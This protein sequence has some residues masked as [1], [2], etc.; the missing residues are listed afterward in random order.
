MEADEGQNLHQLLKRWPEKE[1]WEGAIRDR[2][3]MERRP[4]GLGRCCVGQLP[5]RRILPTQRAGVGEGRLVKKV[6]WEPE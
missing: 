1:D 2:R 3:N 5:L 4:A 6:V